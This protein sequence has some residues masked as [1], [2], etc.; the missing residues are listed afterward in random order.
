MS[1]GPYIV[2][3]TGGIA[4]GKSAVMAI[5]ADLGAEI[6]DA[7]LVYRGLVQPG[8]PLLVRLGDHFGDEV[9]AA[10]G[11]LDRRALGAI[12]FS[13][14]ARLA[15]LDALTH[16]AVRAEID[17]R[18]TASAAGIVAIEAV[19]LIE[20]GH[21]AACDETW[22]VVAPPEVQ[23]ARLMSR[24]GISP[25]EAERRL[26][27]QPAEASRRAVVDRVIDNSGTLDDL[28]RAIEALWSSLSPACL[29]DR[30]DTLAT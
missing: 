18:V 8:Q 6:L 25:E 23:R 11:H 1:G 28:R 24:A 30:L 26:A 19:K 13:D 12:V 27:A 9:I 20:S 29:P 17:A 3:V 16:P 2:G 21:A 4:T 5:L 15:E 7:D 22:L 10:D 14:P